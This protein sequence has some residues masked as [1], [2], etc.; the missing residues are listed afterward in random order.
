MTKK[1]E[2]YKCLESNA[3]K[4]EKQ[5][6]S[7]LPVDSDNSVTNAMR[8]AVLNGGK[9]LRAFIVIEASK[10]FSIPEQQALQAAAAPPEADPQNPHQPESHIALHSGS[11]G[12]P[13][14]GGIVCVLFQQPW[15][16]L[17]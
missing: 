8:Y 7:L 1:S 14:L 15:F 17:G 13:S 11:S 3:R 2:F 9:R 4:T 10:I 12:F 6:D 16:V 5:L